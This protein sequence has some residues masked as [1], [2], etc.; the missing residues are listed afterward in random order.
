MKIK[1]LII[2]LAIILMGFSACQKDSEVELGPVYPMC[3][4]WYVTA[5]YYDADGNEYLDDY[6]LL[7][8]SNTASYSASELLITDNANWWNFKV[9]SALNLE[10]KSFNV[11]NTPNLVS[12]YEELIVSVSNGKVLL[13]GGISTGGNV[14]DSIYM[15]VMFSDAEDSG[16][17]TTEPVTFSG[18]RRTGF[19]EDEH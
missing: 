9:K 12:G 7:T 17:S 6:F 2:V 15:E 3:G 11:S 4:E 13:D 8:T 19:L 5:K 14:S 18:V 16:L 10:G 1:N